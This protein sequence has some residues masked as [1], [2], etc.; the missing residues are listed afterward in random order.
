MTLRLPDPIV[1]GLCGAAGAG[2]DTAADYLCE[3][4]GFVRYAFAEPLRNML[5][6]MLTEAGIDYAWVHERALKEQPIPGLGISYRRLA[7]TLGTE[8]GRQTLHA[9]FWLALAELHLGL[10]GGPTA[11]PVHDRIVITDVRFPNEAAWVARRGG[12]VVRVQRPA[13]AVAAHVSEAHAAHLA[14]WL[15]LDNSGSVAALHDQLD[16]MLDALPGAIGTP[17]SP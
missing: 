11:A 4:A 16:A 8:W 7:Q 12:V 13:P 10:H 3:H 15:T 17:E 1:I 5:E 14:A 6:L 2:K 9:D